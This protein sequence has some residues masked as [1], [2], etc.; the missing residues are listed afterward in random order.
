[1]TD[2]PSK[3]KSNAGRK[4]KIPQALIEKFANCVR[5]GNYLETAAAFC[6][7]PKSTMNSWFEKGRKN[8]RSIYAQFVEAV[9]EAQAQ[10]E[11]RDVINIDQI[12]MG[13]KN[14]YE[15]DPVTNKILFDGN[16]DPI[17]K[18]YGFKPNWQASAWRLERKFPKKWGRHDRLDVTSKGK[19]IANSPAPVQ[20]V[21]IK[22]P[23]KKELPE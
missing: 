13:K 7:I 15:R 18:E 23:A 3:K 6:G 14:V 21:I 11:V 17:I 1:M 20:Q 12:A 4:P 5:A 19:E 22:L 2:E 10:A 8:K 9:E 16:G